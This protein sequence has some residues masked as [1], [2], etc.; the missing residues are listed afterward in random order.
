MAYFICVI[1]LISLDGMNVWELGRKYTEQC[2]MENIYFH[3]S[4]CHA[5]GLYEKRGQYTLNYVGNIVEKHEKLDH[6][7]RCS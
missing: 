4:I 1:R 2:Q 3:L 7:I 6:T 5:T